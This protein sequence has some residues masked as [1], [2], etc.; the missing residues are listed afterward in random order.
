ML[1]DENKKAY[2]DSEA[3]QGP[4]EGWLKIN[5]DGAFKQDSIEDGICGIVSDSSGAVFDGVR[6]E[7]FC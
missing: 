6:E 4:P 1:T 5:F 7:Y 3:W 2:K